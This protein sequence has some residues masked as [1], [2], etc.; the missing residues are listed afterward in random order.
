MTPADLKM[1]PRVKLL[2][3]KLSKQHAA[4]LAKTRVELALNF[5]Y[6]D[7]GVVFADSSIFLSGFAPC[8]FP[9]PNCCRHL[10]YGVL[11]LFHGDIR[12][13]SRIDVVQVDFQAPAISFDEDFLLKHW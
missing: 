6:S 5:G 4:I 7:F 8:G 2:L 12:R 3:M 9:C 11:S 10:R 1:H 13:C